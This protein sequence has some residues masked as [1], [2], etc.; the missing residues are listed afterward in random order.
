[1]VATEDRRFFKH[2]GLDPP[3]MSR[4][5]F[6]NLRAGRVAQGG[7]TLTQQL[8]KNLFLGSE[9]TLAR[10]LEELVLALWLEVRLGKRDILELYLNRVYFG[11]GAYGVE[12]AAQRFFGKSAREVT[13]VEAAVLAG[14]AEGALQVFAGLQ[15]ADGARARQQR[16]G[17][18]GGGGPSVG[19]GGREGRRAAPRFAE[20]AAARAVGPRLRGRC[21]AGAAAVA[22]RRAPAGEMVVETT[23]DAQS[24]APR[25][26]ARA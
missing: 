6:A 25:P 20:A 10:K 5:A 18:D 11:A 13:L 17:Q 8:A 9:R 7:S 16:A 14:P 21:R 4:A 15:S 22:G 3:G 26:G 2:W 1:M 23:I 19:G 12:T 24:A